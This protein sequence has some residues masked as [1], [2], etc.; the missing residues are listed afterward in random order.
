MYTYVSIDD[1]TINLIMHCKK[2]VLFGDDSMWTKKNGSIFDVT[3]GSYNG[4]EI[5]E[6]IGLYVL[7]KLNKNIKN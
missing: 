3:M 1:D 6:L 5:C 7:H 4:A 2:S